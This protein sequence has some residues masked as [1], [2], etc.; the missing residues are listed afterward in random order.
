[1]KGGQ[2]SAKWVEGG[3]WES[4]AGGARPGSRDAQQARRVPACE[5]LGGPRPE[6]SFFWLFH[7]TAHPHLSAAGAV[8][9]QYFPGGPSGPQ[10]SFE[11]AGAPV[12]Q[13]TPAGEV[14]LAWQSEA[15][16][17]FQPLLPILHPQPE[18]YV[19]LLSLCWPGQGWPEVM[20]SLGVAIVPAL[21]V[22]W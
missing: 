3:R 22:G 20:P 14:E 10:S 4:R 5:G 16:R 9:G 7:L 1:M 13:G 2:V 15:E 11:L 6:V 21:P 8:R 17:P 12:D 18:P 19:W